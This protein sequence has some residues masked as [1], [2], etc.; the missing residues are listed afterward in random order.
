MDWTRGRADPHMHI[1]FILLFRGRYDGG[2]RNVAVLLYYSTWL[3][4]HREWEKA[5][6][7]ADKQSDDTFLS[8]KKKCQ[9][10]NFLQP[11]WIESQ[12][13]CTALSPLHADTI[14]HTTKEFPTAP[15]FFVN[16]YNPLNMQS[17][18]F[19]F[20]PCPPAGPALVS[21]WAVTSP[22]RFDAC[23][24]KIQRSSGGGES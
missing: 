24:W 15:S 6:N 16:Q 23:R 20:L 2:F 18:V 8:V 9:K 11:S 3:A 1:F 4:V 10:E 5:R 12:C 22:V 14:G 19:F 13:C 7:A 17:P 21:Q